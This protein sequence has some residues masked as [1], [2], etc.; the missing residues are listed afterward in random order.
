MKFG[1]NH[2]VPKINFIQKLFMYRN[3]SYIVLNSN[4]KEKRKDS[5]NNDRVRV[6]LTSRL[7][8]LFRKNNY[9]FRVG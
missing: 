4:P 6:V 5:A 9:T 3:R 2:S 8:E 7:D 1:V